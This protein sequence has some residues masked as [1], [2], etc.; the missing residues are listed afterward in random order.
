[1]LDIVTIVVQAGDGGAGAVSFR[2]E[3]NAPRGGPDGG[4]G[5]DGGSVILQG[6][7]NETTLAGF[8]YRKHLEAEP[9]VRGEHK[10]M[11]G[12]KGKDL[13]VLAPL[14]THAWRLDDSGGVRLKGD[15]VTEGQKLVLAKGGKGGRG[16]ARF[17]TATQQVPYI[18]EKGQPGETFRYRLELRLLADVGVVGKPNAGKSTL[19]S[20]A[21][22][23]SPKIAPYPFTTL[24]PVLG[25]VT[26]AWKTFVLMEIPGLLKG[27]H[28][29]VGLGHEFLRHA[30]RTR[31][32]IHLVDGSQDDVSGAVREINDE[33]Q[34]Y[35]GGLESRP[36]IVA[37]NKIDMPEVE[38]RKEAILRDLAWV[39]VPVRFLSAAGNIGI[40]EL[41]QEAATL[42]DTLPK[43]KASVIEAE[44]AVTSEET[45]VRKAGGVY[46]VLNERAVRF[47]EGSNLREWEG[48]VQV[49]LRLDRLGVT[50]ALEEAGI[51]HGDMVRFGTLELEW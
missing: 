31:A 36:Q 35:G 8:K 28:K 12:K 22:K 30:T 11:F 43:A 38:A 41:M 15:L 50:R 40:Q 1:M 33:L 10:N 3:K 18:A 13:Q 2:H 51:K 26:V 14:G 39:K 46:E 9:G 45:K 32:L 49:K 47:V 4:D 27:A 6:T 25:V 17:A 44:I 37:V 23:A 20:V 19:L 34:A 5:G 42:L 29:G 21:T 48:R 24:E 16:N 7:S